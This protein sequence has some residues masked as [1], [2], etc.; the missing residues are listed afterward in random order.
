MS[1]SAAASTPSFDL[2]PPAHLV[3][4]R[5]RLMWRVEALLLVAALLAVQLVWWVVGGR[6]G[7]Q[8]HLLL[9]G[10]TLLL[11]VGYAVLMPAWRYRVHRWEATDTAVY[12]QTGWLTQERRIAPISRIQTVDMQRGPVAQLFALASVRVT[13]ASA[14]GPL[15]IDGLDDAAA[16][17]LVDEL[18]QL[19][20]A[21]PGD[22]T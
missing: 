1:E 4:P 9:A 15:T 7:A 13:T 18:T 5:A 21:T 11:G 17:A 3:S 10:A 22:A 8:V 6:W 14:A 12:T 2:R 19:T 20:T 16:R